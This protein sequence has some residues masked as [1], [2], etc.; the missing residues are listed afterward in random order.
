[1]R[2]RKGRVVRQFP[3]SAP[4]L[5]LLL[6]S[7]LLDVPLPSRCSFNDRSLRSGT[8]IDPL[9]GNGKSRRFLND[10]SLDLTFSLVIPT[11][12][13]SKSSPPL[14]R[15]N[16]REWYDDRVSIISEIRRE[17]FLSGRSFVLERISGLDGYSFLS[18]SFQLCRWQG[19][20]REQVSTR[21][22]IKNDSS[23]Y[24]GCA[25]EEPLFTARLFSFPRVSF[26]SS[27]RSS[28]HRTRKV[29]SARCTG[30]KRGKIYIETFE[31]RNKFL[32]SPISSSS[33][34][35]RFSFL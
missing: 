27:S 10:K 7:G 4:T 22:R 34:G 35:K 31:A 23:H 25:C 8:C 29:I 32:I 30:K 17:N 1:M 13:I 15:W 11:R 3:P 6:I 5:A 14:P 21:E 28:E 18:F 24:G 9:G 16:E 26:S 33:S 19:L 20:S 2:C 12:G